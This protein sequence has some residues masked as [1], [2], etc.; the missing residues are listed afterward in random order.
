V[1]R[2]VS[3]QFLNPKT[4][5]KTT[6]TEVQSVARPLLA[7]TQNKYRHLHSLSGIRTH[8]PS[9]RAGEDSSCLSQRG[10]CDRLL[11]YWEPINKSATYNQRSNIQLNRLQSLVRSIS[12]VSY[13]V[14]FPQCSSNFSVDVMSSQA[15]RHD[16]EQSIE[17]N[18]SD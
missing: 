1:K 2:F 15:C 3:F 8:D 5:G 16:Y 14:H 7:K 13:M 17:R 10:Y 11:Y 18:R 12:L 9:V 6:W 4:V